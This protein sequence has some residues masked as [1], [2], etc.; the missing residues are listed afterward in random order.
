MKRKIRPVEAST[1]ESEGTVFYKCTADDI[2]KA[3]DG[4][5]ENCL[6]LWAVNNYGV[7]G[8]DISTLYG[9]FIHMN[10]LY[11]CVT[12]NEDIEVNGDMVDPEFAFDSYKFEYLEPYVKPVTDKILKKYI[13]DYEVVNF[14]LDKTIKGMIDDGYSMTEMLKSDGIRRLLR[15]GLGLD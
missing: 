8:I 1:S 11:L 4:E 14:G 15:T 10:D 7:N 3:F 6:I 2:I 5:D 12:D 9:S 13:T